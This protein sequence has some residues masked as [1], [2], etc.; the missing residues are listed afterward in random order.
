[1]KILLLGAQ[2]QLG[3]EL[4]AHLSAMSDLKACGRNQVDLTSQE[5]IEQAIRSFKPDCIVNAAAYTAVDKA[6]SEPELAFKIN[7]KAVS[8]IANEA[9]K[10]DAL[11]IHYSTDYVFDGKN[12]QPYNEQDATNPI[13]VYGESKLAGEEAII[14]SGCKHFIFRTTWVIGKH[15]SNFAKTILRLAQERE[16]LKIINDQHGVPTTTSL[17]SRITVTAIKS[18][19]PSTWPYGI[20]HLAPKGQTTWYGIAKTLLELAKEKEITLAISSLL[21]ITTS[22]YPTPASRPSNSLLNTNKLEALI[23][24]ELPYWEDEFLKVANHIIKDL[25]QK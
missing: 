14:N 4:K 9:K 6:E 21:P 2:G 11:L 20:Y 1:M 15:G 18:S 10:I 25:Q 12:T 5:S 13:S 23:N 19:Q 16:Q 24:F 3:Q 7:T 22:Q 8:V 17:I